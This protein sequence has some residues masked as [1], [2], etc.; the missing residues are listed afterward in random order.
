MQK[1]ATVWISAYP[2]SRAL[3]QIMTNFQFE[4]N[5]LKGH[6]PRGKISSLIPSNRRRALRDAARSAKPNQKKID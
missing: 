3:K 5:R 6:S 2:A 4:L 1:R